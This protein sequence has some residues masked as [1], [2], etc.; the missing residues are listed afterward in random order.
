[1]EEQSGHRQ[2][3]PRN[4]ASAHPLVEIIES[5]LFELEGTIKGHLAQLPCN[6]QGHLQLDQVAQ[7]LPCLSNLCSSASESKTRDQTDGRSNWNTHNQCRPY[8]IA[9]AR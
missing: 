8:R 4:S 7:S 2:E 6:D 9:S 3:V 1:M 5:E